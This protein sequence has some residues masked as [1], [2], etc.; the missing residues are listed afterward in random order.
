MVSKN[1]VVA[2]ALY[3]FSLHAMNSDPRLA[4]AKKTAMDRIA[5][6]F[7]AQDHLF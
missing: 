6:L 7:R 3:S 5:V 2:V 1:I 4:L